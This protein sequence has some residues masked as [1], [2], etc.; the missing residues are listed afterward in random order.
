M[1]LAGAAGGA[2][3]GAAEDMSVGA[4]RRSS[5]GSDSGERVVGCV[6]AA[7]FPRWAQDGHRLEPTLEYPP[8]GYSCMF[9][10]NPTS[11]LAHTEPCMEFLFLPIEQARVAR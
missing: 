3:A 4:K 1:E 8:G 2:L 6:G 10:Y 5:G 7:P 9:D 11:E